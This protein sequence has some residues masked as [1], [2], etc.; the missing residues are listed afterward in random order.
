MAF[1]V[2]DRARESHPVVGIGAVG[3]PIVQIRERDAWIGWDAKNFLNSAVSSPTADLGEWLCKIVDCAINELFID[4]FLETQLIERRDLA[5]P[6]TEAIA[7][8]K[9]HG[10]TQRELH[11]R[12]VRLPEHKASPIAT[13]SVWRERAQTHLYRSKRALSLAELLRARRT[14][15][16][17]LGAY[18]TAESVRAL[19]TNPEGVRTVRTILRKAKADRVGIAMAD[20]T[21]CGAVE[22]Y[23]QILGGKLVSMLSASPE[24]ILAYRNRYAEQESEIASSMA[25][26]PVVRPSQLVLLG[27]TSLYGVGSSQYNRLKMPA[28]L[29]GGRRG[30][31][32]QYRRLGKSQAYGTSQFSA[33]TVDAL[34]TLVEQTSNGRRVN[35]IFGEG[36]SPK[37]RKLR[38]GLSIL[39]LNDDELLQH[40]R[41]RIVYGV[42]LVRNLSQFLLGFDD[43]PDYLLSLENPENATET[44]VDWW[45]RRWLSKRVMNDEILARLDRHSLVRPI[46]HGAR[47]VLPRPNTEQHSLFEDIDN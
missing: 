16:Q 37:F 15:H 4:D 23:S 45:T 2:R 40:G 9:N 20:I 44:I 26:R 27:T 41:H 7:R 42:Q 32:L 35:S 22:P 36:V 24:V 30:E 13:G 10:E 38:E 34:V 14:L 46:R 12:F 47:V 28:E 3:S 25:G 5:E 18:P 6:S 8:L 11:H 21:V 43:E 39:G 33:E 29:L 19:I 17:S 31:Y 1:L